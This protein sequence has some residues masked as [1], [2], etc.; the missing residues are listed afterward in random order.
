MKK[1][2]SG[3]GIIWFFFKPYKLRGLG[4]IVLSVLIGGLEAASVAAVYPI[5][6]TAF[7]M[8]AA[9]G[10]F[11]LAVFG[12]LASL[13]PISDQF[14]TY[15]VLFLI[16]V[17]LDFAVKM[18]SL[19]FRTRFGVEIVEKNQNEVFGK[20]MQADYQYFINHKQGDLIYNATIAPSAISAQ[21][22]GITSLVTQGVLAV[23]VL[24][25][26][27]SLSWRGTLVVLF[28]GLIYYFFTRYLGR[29][30]SYS[31]GRGEMAAWQEANV[32]LNEAISGIKQVKVFVSEDTW[33]KRFTSSMRNRW[34]YFLRRSIWRQVPPPI[35]NLV[36]YFSIGL[37][38]IFM[39]LLVPPASFTEAIPLF[40]T[41]AF[42]IF[43]LS[44]LVTALGEL[45]MDIMGSLPNCEMVY[46]IQSEKLTKIEDGP[47]EFTEFKSDIRFED[48]S[49]AYK[50]REKTLEG[51]SVWFEKG[52]TTAIVGRSGEG[53]TTFIN[54]ILRL[55]DIDKGSIKIDGVDIREYRLG[56]WLSNIGYVSQDTFIFNDTVESNI[57]FRS[58]RYTR[59][60][61]IQAA[62]YADAHEF[63]TRLPEGY[64]TL[65]GDKGVKLSGGQAQ[66]IAVARAIIRNPEILIFDEAT[67]NL[68]N[69]SEKIV[70]KAID[71]ISRGHTAIIVAHRLSTIVNAD[72]II[73][74]ENGQVAEEGTHLELIDKKGAYWRL[75][76]KHV[77]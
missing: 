42:A 53:K 59:E 57:T 15:C 71:E 12:W 11:I 45:A 9:P 56:S 72:K 55:F 31:A 5:L 43:R 51:I 7:T 21:I 40:G 69:I 74:I 75:Y 54:L 18:L 58:G 1:R 34:D 33:N 77:I 76:Q 61:V 13:L 73:V 3:L 16:L 26:L 70:Q 49:F 4:L 23:S 66:R 8:G 27:F 30:V 35:L 22:N 37:V 24:A 39:K 29:K 50:G 6:T 14:V 10:N 38:A 60:E 47:R 36:I 17:F 32:V 64:E 25:L 20:F 52:R 46:N 2:K 48:V 68:D 44:P 62:K 63:I 41:F 67:N 28:I 19:N 65:V